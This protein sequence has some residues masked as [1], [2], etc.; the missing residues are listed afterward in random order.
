[1]GFGDFY[2]N[3]RKL[4]CDFYCQNRNNRVFGV[5][6]SGINEVQTQIMGIPELVV[7][8]VSGH[9]GVASG[10]QGSKHSVSAASTTYGYLPDR[11]AA[12]NIAK[13]VAA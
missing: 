2:F 10:I 5:E 1:M 13:A 6:M 8:D 9:E 12:V 7:F 11:L 4:G 3:F